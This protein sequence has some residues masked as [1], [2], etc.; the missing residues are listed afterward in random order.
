MI[1]WRTV[2]P[3][4]LEPTFRA[5]VEELLERSPYLWVVTHGYRSLAEQAALHK[6]Y[7][8]GGPLAAPAGQSAHNYGLAIDVALDGDPEKPGLQPTWDT[9]AA[10]WTW[11]KAATLP[12]PRLQNGWS[13]H[14]WPHIQRY[15]WR[16]FVNWRPTPLV[17]A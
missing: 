12:H 3:D 5:D 4:L 9:K 2:N 13:F 15:R 11:L 6:R 16:Q 7:R 10:G 8:E 14:D 17:V 1:D